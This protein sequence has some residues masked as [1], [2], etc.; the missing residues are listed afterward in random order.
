V[1]LRRLVL[2][3]DLRELHRLEIAPSNRLLPSA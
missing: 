3:S 2:G 1:L